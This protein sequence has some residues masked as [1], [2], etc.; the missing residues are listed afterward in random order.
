M[1]E[2]R[3]W[4]AVCASARLEAPVTLVPRTPPPD[5]APARIHPGKRLCVVM[6]SGFACVSLEVAPSI[7]SGLGVGG[8]FADETACACGNGESP[9][10]PLMTT[11]L[12]DSRARSVQLGNRVFAADFTP[13][14]LLL[15]AANA[16]RSLCLLPQS[17]GTGGP[18]GACSRPILAA[19]IRPMELASSPSSEIA[20]SAGY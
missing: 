9:S 17:A 8:S 1:P 3:G 15:L 4:T 7:F 18:P 20:M 5:S 10:A 12:L 2:A 16:A 6:S 13:P 14:S 19:P 11:V